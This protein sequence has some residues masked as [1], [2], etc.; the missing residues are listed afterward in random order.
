MARCRDKKKG[1]VAVCLA[2]TRGVHR[3]YRC[4]PPGGSDKA[5]FLLFLI[6]VFLGFSFGQLSVQEPSLVLSISAFLV[7]I[8]SQKHCSSTCWWVR[9]NDGARLF[10]LLLRRGLFCANWDVNRDRQWFVRGVCSFNELRGTEGPVRSGERTEGSVAA[11]GGG[12]EKLLSF[13]CFILF[14]SLRPALRARGVD[15]LPL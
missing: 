2:E 12:A 9:G 7:Q 15:L 11:E 14:S 1:V 3:C 10:L 5:V 4:L 6:L 13:L 8:V